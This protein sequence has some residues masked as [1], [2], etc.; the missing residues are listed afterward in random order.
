M[1][2]MV[3]EMCMEGQEE[4]SV[5]EESGKEVDIVLVPS[6]RQEWVGESLR[7]GMG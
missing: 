2:V 6:S 1:M 4:N 3:V 7:T 5:W